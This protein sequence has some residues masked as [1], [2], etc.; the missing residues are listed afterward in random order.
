VQ[1]LQ[2]F[3]QLYGLWVVRVSASQILPFGRLK[4]SVVAGAPFA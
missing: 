4:A 3:S 2:P 1:C